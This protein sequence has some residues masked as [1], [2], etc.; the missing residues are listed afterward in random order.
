MIIAT[1]LNG[2]ALFR[3]MFRAFLGPMKVE[4]PADLQPRE[5]AVHGGLAV[6]VFGLGLWPA[7]LLE[8]VALAAPSIHP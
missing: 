8:I 7:P 3:A 1:A 5:L 6:L 4:A 2:I